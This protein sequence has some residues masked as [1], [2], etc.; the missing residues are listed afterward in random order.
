MMTPTL[1]APSSTSCA[2]FGKKKTLVQM[3][4]Q[5]AFARTTICQMTHGKLASCFFPHPVSFAGASTGHV[6]NMN[7]FRNKHLHTYQP[8][9]LITTIGFIGAIQIKDIQLELCTSKT[10]KFSSLSEVA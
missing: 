6:N 4:S 10:L 9:N 8:L 3:R 2:F 1:C 5:K 7:E